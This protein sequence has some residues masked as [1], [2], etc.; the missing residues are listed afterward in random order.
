MKKML[1][2]FLLLVVYS[3]GIFAKDPQWK[4]FN[5]G[6]VEAKKS[7]KKILVDVYTDWC[8]WCKEMD[9]NTYADKNISAYLNKNFVIIKLNAE[10]NEIINYAGQS[11][12]PQDFAQRMGVDGYPATVFLKSDGQAITLLPGYSKPDQFIHV[13]SFISE[14]HYLKKQFGD[15]LSEKGVKH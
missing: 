14:N 2:I 3:T 7:G 12:T 13:L 9:K 5:E 8:K 6:I 10:G 11:I 4:K 1:L 15:Y